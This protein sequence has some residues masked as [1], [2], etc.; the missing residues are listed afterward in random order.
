MHPGFANV[1]SSIVKNQIGLPG[2]QLFAKISATFIG[3]NVVYHCDTAG[4][5]LDRGQI[6]SN[7]EGGHGH[8]LLGHL[9]P[10]SWSC[11]KDRCKPWISEETQ[12][13][14]SV[15]R[16]WTKLWICNQSPWLTSMLCPDGTSLFW[17]FYP[18]LSVM[19]KSSLNFTHFTWWC[20]CLITPAQYRQGCTLWSEIWATCA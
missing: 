10:W 14:C 2:L 18:S 7:D 17:P 15:G 13:F 5:G 3:C 8:V 6:H 9:H 20:F 4:N 12:I 19:K 11:A 1:R 16:V